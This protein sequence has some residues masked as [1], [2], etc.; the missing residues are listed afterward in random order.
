MRPESI[1]KKEDDF[2][3]DLT[4]SAGVK[5]KLTTTTDIG[6]GVKIY[7]IRP[8]YNSYYY[9]TKTVKKSICLHF[10]VGYIKSDVT[11]LSTKDNFVSVSYLVDRSGCIYEMFPDAEWS[12]HLGSGAIGGNGSM[13]KQ[14]IGIEI[15]NY[16]QLKLSG[17]NLV[18]AYGSVY[19]NVSENQFYDK[20]NYRGYDYFASMTDV[21]IDAVSALIKYLGR[22]HDIPMNFK[23]DDAPFAN[24]A[25]AISFKGV[26]YHTNVRKD[27][28]DWPFTPSLKAVIAKCSSS[29][30]PQTEAKADA[31]KVETT[32]PETPKTD[33]P[34][35]Q[36]PASE[37]TSSAE[38]PAAVKP[39]AKPAVKVVPRMA[40]AKKS[41]SLFESVIS[42]IIQLFVNKKH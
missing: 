8:N 6:N 7:S 42:L 40:P 23:S 10:T 33:A 12:Y 9:K 38:T 32:T 18:D 11:A 29:N 2:F 36:T 17:E 13:S 5:Y 21:Q 37:N 16:G 24:N 31:T 35:P 22:T 25:E 26:F 39:A 3:Q 34:K 19:C 4:N 15:S 14:S 27:K 1:Q 30:P 41:K 28:F 20:Q